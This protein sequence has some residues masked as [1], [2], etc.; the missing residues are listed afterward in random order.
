[1]LNILKVVDYCVKNFI[2]KHCDIIKRYCI[3]TVE[4]VNI[5]LTQ[6]N[7]NFGF[8]IPKTKIKLKNYFYK[9]ALN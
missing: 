2:K 6:N 1:M 4:H 3:I 5:F 7:Y 9:A 8:T